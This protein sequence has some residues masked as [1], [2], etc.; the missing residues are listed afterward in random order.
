MRKTNSLPLASKL[1]PM[2]KNSILLKFISF[3]SFV[4]IQSGRKIQKTLLST[5]INRQASFH[6]FLKTTYP[7]A[8]KQKT[9]LVR[10]FS[11]ASNVDFSS[12]KI[13]FEQAKFKELKGFYTY[14]LSKGVKFRRST[15]KVPVGKTGSGEELTSW[16]SILL[17]L[18]SESPVYT[19]MADLRG[20]NFIVLDFDTYKASLGEAGYALE[21]VYFKLINYI[22]TLSTNIK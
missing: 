4:L 21:S 20:T 13:P 7:I 6:K 2:F 10:N 5:T 9:L 8:T 17:A 14:L 12:I 1:L 19:L 15:V 18:V 11:S 16:D 22:T 3:L